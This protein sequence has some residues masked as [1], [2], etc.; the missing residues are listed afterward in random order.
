MSNEKIRLLSVLVPSD[1]HHFVKV[2]QHRIL[3]Y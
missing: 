2:E 1:G 3:S